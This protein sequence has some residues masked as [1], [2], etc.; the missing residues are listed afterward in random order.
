MLA[1][2]NLRIGA[3]KRASARQAESLNYG[4]LF[5]RPRR[6]WLQSTCR[7][8]GAPSRARAPDA[9]PKC[10]VVGRL[11]HRRIATN[12]TRTFEIGAGRGRPCTNPRPT[13]RPQMPIAGSALCVLPGSIGAAWSIGSSAPR[14]AS[15][16]R[17]PRFSGPLLP[18]N[19]SAC[20]KPNNFGH[21][22]LRGIWV[23]TFDD[24]RETR[25]AEGHFRVISVWPS[26]RSSRGFC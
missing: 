21:S 26:S 14:F 6:R 4:K 3:L 11:D 24:G 13:R 15:R 25:L 2:A 12:R 8:R 20:L 22:N 9:R 18:R 5:D 1:G 19:P 16:K 17:I 7:Q 23:I 10:P